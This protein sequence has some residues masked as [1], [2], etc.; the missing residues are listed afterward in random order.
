M[1]GELPQSYLSAE[2][3]GETFEL[4]PPERNLG[5]RVTA[6]LTDLVQKISLLLSHQID[7]RRAVE[8]REVESQFSRTDLG[9]Q[10]NI[11]PECRTAKGCI[12]AGTVRLRAPPKPREPAGFQ[13]HLKVDRL[14]IEAPP[15]S[16]ATCHRARTDGVA[17][18][19]HPNTP[20]AA[21]IAK[22]RWLSIDFSEELSIPNHRSSDLMPIT[23]YHR[24]QAP[25]SLRLFNAERL[26]NNTLAFGEPPLKALLVLIRVQ[27]LQLGYQP[28]LNPGPFFWSS[29]YAGRFTSQTGC[30][31]TRI[32]LPVL[33]FAFGGN[34]ISI[35]AESRRC[36]LTWDSRRAKD[37]KMLI[38]NEIP[39]RKKRQAPRRPRVASTAQLAAAHGVM[40]ENKICTCVDHPLC[41]SCLL[42][43][44]LC[45]V[46]V[47]P[48]NRHNHVIS[49]FFCPANECIQCFE[50]CFAPPRPPLCDEIDLA[51]VRTE[52]LR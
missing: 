18:T 14:E 26:Q 16:P 3:L 46:F 5:C 8:L 17:A 2:A 39:E 23:M 13:F 24:H 38:G 30:A 4:G 37:I 50:T 1:V 42:L 34:S 22:S 25:S 47:A 7:P 21:Q 27:G 44:R 49:L 6:D 51:F 19:A 40:T 48:M 33:S 20:K 11:P 35:M 41:Q 15:R 36:R 52:G 31:L 28:W 29:S 45:H 12:A 32:A 10:L 9:R 43:A